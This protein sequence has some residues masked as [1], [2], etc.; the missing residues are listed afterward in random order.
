MYIAYC[1]PELLPYVTGHALYD[2]TIYLGSD[3]L[4]QIS[5]FDAP[6][7]G[8]APLAPE[9]GSIFYKYKLA[10]DPPEQVG[11]TEFSELQ[12]DL[13]YGVPQLLATAAWRWNPGASWS[14]GVV[15]FPIADP[16]HPCE[17]A[18]TGLSR[19]DGLALLLDDNHPNFGTRGM[20][21]V[22]RVTGGGAV[23][24]DPYVAAECSL[25]ALQWRFS[26]EG[27]SGLALGTFDPT[28]QAYPFAL[29][30]TERIDLSPK[31]VERIPPFSER[32]R[33]FDT[34]GFGAASLAFDPYSH[35]LFA[36][37]E[38][39]VLRFRADG[40]WVEFLSNLTGAKGL[41]FTWS[42]LLVVSEPGQLVA[43]DGWRYR[44]KRGDAD[45]NLQVNITDAIY[46]LNYLFQGGPQPGCWDAADVKD[47]S[48]IDQ[49]DAVYLM[50]YLFLG[51]PP[52]P[53][54]YSDLPDEGFGA[55]PTP[56]LFGCRS[57]AAEKAVEW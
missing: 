54:P 28:E 50:N 14:K 1:N 56:D 21:Y 55:D 39:S 38:V 31:V 20:Y 16:E 32:R 6:G 25:R 33:V 51:G 36:P 12:L 3:W 2:R 43:V 9:K 23:Y 13:S 42:G 11:V 48:T 10:G 37:S 57:Y 41:S 7:S 29:Y 40:T 27:A 46:I 8:Q 45:A 53:P 34:G 4:S 26:A 44:F 5:G 17:E 49:A 47:D 35:T 52:P 19:T 24:R 22:S 15:R 18:L 30:H